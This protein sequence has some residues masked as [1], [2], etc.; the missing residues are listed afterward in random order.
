[1]A[2]I[3]GG[4]YLSMGAKCAVSRRDLSGWDWSGTT[5]SEISTF[6]IYARWQYGIT[7]RAVGFAGGS[8]DWRQQWQIGD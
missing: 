2:G 4:G 8:R 6:P 5:K 1:V 3:L 7:R